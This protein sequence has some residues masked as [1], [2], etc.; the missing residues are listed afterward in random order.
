[1]APL[2]CELFSTADEGGRTFFIACWLENSLETK[3]HAQHEKNTQQSNIDNDQ[4]FSSKHQIWNITNGSPIKSPI[5]NCNRPGFLPSFIKLVQQFI[6]RIVKMK[7]FLPGQKRLKPTVNFPVTP[8]PFR[9]K[10]VI[11]RRMTMRPSVTQL[12]EVVDAFVDWVKI[13]I[14]CVDN[15]AGMGCRR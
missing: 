8:V 11:V 5:L 7:N 12:Q 3:L 13:A 1:M 9:I 4:K 10:L 6:Q 14:L 2:F 15:Q